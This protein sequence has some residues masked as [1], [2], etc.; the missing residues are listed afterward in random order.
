[1]KAWVE[2]QTLPPEDKRGIASL[3][4]KNGYYSVETL[5]MEDPEVLLGLPEV[6]ALVPG[7]K[8]VLKKAFVDLK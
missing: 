7:L 5:K 8:V 2:K 4:A 3:L 1:L 6:Q